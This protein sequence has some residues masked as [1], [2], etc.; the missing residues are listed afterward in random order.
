M[1]KTILKKVILVVALLAFTSAGAQTLQWT[2]S[3]KVAIQNLANDSLLLNYSLSELLEIRNHYEQETSRLI[4]EKDRLRGIGIRDLE[5][6]LAAAPA[7]SDMDKILIRLADLHYEQAQR[8]YMAALEKSVM[9]ST[10]ADP[11][12][13]YER[14]LALYQQIIDGYPESEFL[15]DAYYNKG[16]LFEELTEFDSA[17]IAYQDVINRF[18]Q[19]NFTPDAILRLAEYYFNPPVAEYETAIV[20]YKKVLQYKESPIYDAALYRLGWCYYK[21]SDYPSAISY[22]TVLSDDIDRVKKLD[23]L[24]KHHFPAVRDE[25]HEYIGISFLDFGGALQA[26]SYFDKI[27]GREYGYAV[28][29]KIADA[30]LDVKEE[31]ANAVSAYKFLL[32]MYPET[33]YAPEI[34]SKIVEAYRREKDDKMAYASRIELVAKFNNDG[35]WWQKMSEDDRDK[36]MVL[37]E[38]AVRENIQ[39]QMKKAAETEEIIAYQRAVNDSRK[40]LA[41][42]PVDSNSARVHWNLALTLDTKLGKPGSALVEFITISALYPEG[43]FQKKS[44]E[45]AVAIADEMVKKEALEIPGSNISTDSVLTDSEKILITALDNYIKVFPHEPGTPKMLAKAGALYYEKKQFK[46]SIKYF[47]TLARHFPDS[48]EMDYARFITMESYFGKEDYRS[49]EL[50]AKKIRD[51]SPEHREKANTRMAEAIFMQANIL[52]D[53]SKHLQAAETY[54]RIIMQAPYAKIADR[55]LFN[56]ALEYEKENNFE[57]AIEAYSTLVSK[58]EY[59]EHWR[60]ALN[61]LA[62]DNREIKNYDEA[63]LAYEKLANANPADSSSQAA[64]FNASISFVQAEEWLSV[65]RINNLYSERYPDADDAD[66]LLFDNANYYLKL[67]NMAQAEVIYTRFTT[68]YPESPKVIAAHYHRGEYYQER[69]DIANAKIQFDLA[70]KKNDG[71]RES[72][73]ETNEF[74][75]SEALFQLSEIKL[76][77]YENIR[78]ASADGTLSSKKEMKKALLNELTGNYARVVSLGTN[79]LYEASYKSGYLFENLARTWA[80][81]S[82]NSSDLNQKIAARNTINQEAAQIYDQ[83]V[84]AYKSNTIALQAFAEKLQTQTAADS[85]QQIEGRITAADTTLQLA[86]TWIEKCKNKVSE[87]LFL[88]AELNTNSMHELLS[89][90]APAEISKLEQLVYHSQVLE[91]LVAP[92]VEQVVAAHRRNIQE[93]SELGFSNLW[94]DSSLTE[95]FAVN[96]LLP[97]AK[98]ILSQHAQNEITALLPNYEN[99]IQADDETAYDVSQQLG[100]FAEFAITQAKESA[101]LFDT[102]MQSAYALGL[103]SLEMVEKEND[104]LQAILAT[105]ATSDSLSLV[106]EASRAEYEKLFQKTEQIN[107]EDAQFTYEDLFFTLN[108]G[109]LA[110]YQA[111]F[112]HS[113]KSVIRE[114]WNPEFGLQLVKLK[115]DEYK[116]KFGVNVFNRFLPSSSDWMV[117]ATSESGWT[118]IDFTDSLWSN[119]YNEGESEFVN[120]RD[121]QKIWLTEFDEQRIVEMD[122]SA[123]GYKTA[124]EIIEQGADFASHPEVLFFRKTFDLTEPELAASLSLYPSG[125]YEL[126]VN[127]VLVH[128]AIKD[129]ADV[130]TIQ[131]HDISTFLKQGKNVV[132]IKITDSGE[133]FIGLESVIEI[134]SI[135][136]WAEV[137]DRLQ[138]PGEDDSLERKPE[139]MLAE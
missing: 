43:E 30:Y 35:S 4:K 74:V 18:P 8:D 40:Y 25:A 100:A 113:Q 52:A 49:T 96:N 51:M 138:R 134:E 99:L 115:P 89:A 28:F 48:P 77:E 101:I 53:S 42:F 131:K 121:V 114:K 133:K 87:N 47:K 127:D 17:A 15:D 13:K 66:D 136:N 16:F 41:S 29:R 10:F 21:L 7:N 97:D 23:P 102:A 118:T 103:D 94:V 50:I 6:F 95:I 128:E 1:K 126:Y 54:M 92:L 2:D 3:S 12:L 111:G 59:S 98:R 105:G 32:A 120:V 76:T 58:Y 56:A 24:I 61:N 65:I 79:R 81:Q 123:A 82:V 135:A 63:G 124:A 67:G 22:F 84:A 26:K 20:Y 68:K 90:P 39:T 64:L 106:A 78:F 62:F 119:A 55:A 108:D 38:K 125:D 27:G 9:D 44:A 14:P 130:K 129:S 109:A 75:F 33:P 93:S 31:Y 112:K 70:V 34:Q 122:T 117:S 69:N 107:F 88:M 73:L 80:E 104:I 85:T 83:A 36:A 19:S 139:T 86:E 71:L 37:A 72:G 110:L 57:K 46:P 45:N 11:P 91:K 60:Q 116:K 5:T 137:K 132:A